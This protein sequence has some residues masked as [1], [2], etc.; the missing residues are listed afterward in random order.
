VALRENASLSAGFGS[1]TAEEVLDALAQRAARGDKAAFEEIFEATSGE[2]YRFARGLSGNDAVAEDI[3]ATTY[4]R[5][6]QSARSY[7]VGTNNYRR[8]LLGIAR[9]QIYDHWRVNN[10]TVPISEMDFVAP[11]ISEGQRS[12]GE[13]RG[14]LDRLLA[15]ITPDQREV[16]VLRYID[17]KSHEEIGRL[18]GKRE[19]A[20][21]AQLL[22]A[23]RHMRKVIR[24][25]SP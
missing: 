19:G 7:R 12:A 11:D 15:T 13:V 14:E 5:A 6:W 3:V 17:N 22:R 9:N 18:L 1:R 8:W 25:A 20:V 21:R 4:L 24:D 23:L 16:V 2:L 10:E